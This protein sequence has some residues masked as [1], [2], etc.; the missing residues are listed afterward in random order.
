MA[1]RPRVHVDP[2]TVTPPRFG[3]WSVIQPVEDADQAHWRLG[4]QHQPDLCQPAGATLPDCPPPDDDYATLTKTP[5]G[6]LPTI[7]ADPF[8]VYAWVDCGPVGGVWEQAQ[9]RAT[10]AL[11][12]GEART[13]ERVFWSG[14]TPAGPV[15][16]HLASNVEITDPG[17]ADPDAYQVLVQPA[18]VVPQDGPMDVVEALA[19]LEQALA[20]CYPGVGVI[21]VTRATAI[22]LAT[23]DLITRQGE[24]LRTPL[25]TRVAAGAGY[26]G[27]APDGT[28]P[29]Y[30]RA[31]MYA[32]GAITGRRSAVSMSSREA[33]LD[34]RRNHLVLIPE[35]T[36]VLS[37]DCCLFAAEV[38]LGGRPAG[39][40]NTPNPLLPL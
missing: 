24:Q 7:G 32:T 15:Y 14:L 39:L 13:V 34:R 1:T 12:G 37:W 35:R 40:H 29:E 25:G 18:A 33:A 36:Y 4:V 19:V 26:P 17:A 21:H 22:H 20:D 2:P 5:T 23:Y 16:P 30:P 28:T 9:A 6:R 10:A 27:T 11:T 8:A 31:W 38:Y 3:L